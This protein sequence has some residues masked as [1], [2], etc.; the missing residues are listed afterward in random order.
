MTEAAAGSAPVPILFDTDLG[1]DVDD[2]IALAFLAQDPRCRLVGVTTVNGDA[3]RRAALAKG[4]LDLMGRGDVPVGVGA[5]R[6]IDGETSPTIF[7]ST[8][9]S[10]RGRPSSRWKR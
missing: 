7:A 6:P 5:E 9:S 8:S 4:L 3:R 2:A 10:R 1:T